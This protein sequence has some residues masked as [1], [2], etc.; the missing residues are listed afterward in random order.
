ML[1][2]ADGMSFQME[3]KKEAKKKLWNITKKTLK[4]NNDVYD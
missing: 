3:R 1:K 2:T 4:V